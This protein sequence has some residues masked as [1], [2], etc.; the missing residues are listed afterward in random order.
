MDEDPL[1]ARSAQAHTIILPD[2]LMTVDETKRYL[3]LLQHMTITQADI[4]TL[5]NR[6]RTNRTE[7]TISSNKRIAYI[8]RF[9]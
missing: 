6:A 9:I 5:L 7:R 4:E 3:E 2:D 1:H 8:Y